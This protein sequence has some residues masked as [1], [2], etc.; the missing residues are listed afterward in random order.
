MLPKT[1]EDINSQP[2]SS[3]IYVDDEAGGMG[4]TVLYQL[5][6]SDIIKDLELTLKN[7]AIN[8]N[9]EIIQRGKPLIN[10]LGA[11]EILSVIKAVLTKNTYLSNLKE[12][13]VN[14][15]IIS[16]ADDITDLLA[17]KYDEFGVD[18]R[19]LSIIHD[20]CVSTIAF[21]IRRPMNQ[22]ER[23]FLKPTRRVIETIHSDKRERSGSLFNIFGKK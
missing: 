1:M 11:S 21:A 3:P 22:G 13:Q 15:E 19:N 12:F 23:V 17:S 20:I 4:S 14:K 9:G 7:Q 10:D 8:E 18:K 2:V 5:D 6:S 16:F